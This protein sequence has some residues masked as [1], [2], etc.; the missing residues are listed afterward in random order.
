MIKIDATLLIQIQLAVVGIVVIVGI[1][2]LWRSI[3]RMENRMDKSFAKIASLLKQHTLPSLSENIHPQFPFV[4]PPQFQNDPSTENLANA[5]EL[6]SQVFGSTM[7]VDQPQMMMFSMAL[8]QEPTEPLSNVEENVCIVEDIQDYPSSSNVKSTQESENTEI[9]KTDVINIDLDD[10][11]NVSVSTDTNP[12]SKSKLAQMKLEKLRSLCEE[13]ELST[14]G[15]K[16]QLI[17]RLLGLT[18][19]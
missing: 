13:R 16:P 12:I 14:E 9:K 3:V 5:Q 1:F 2:Y 11:D 4:I 15:T 7:G 8:N 17:E 19:E 6:M 10:E 18:R